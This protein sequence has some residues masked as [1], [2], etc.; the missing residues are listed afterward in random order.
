MQ[1]ARQLTELG[2]RG[3]DPAQVRGLLHDGAGTHGVVRCLG[4]TVERR[5][6]LMAR[7][8][9]APRQ[10]LEPRQVFRAGG[11]AA[12]AGEAALGRAKIL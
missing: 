3:R 9:H 7:V 2:G 11:E 4:E 5:L 8:R 10:E 12:R 6:V 1:R